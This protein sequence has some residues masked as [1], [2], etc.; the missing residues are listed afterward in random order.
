MVGVS[1]WA[2]IEST[3][4]T[5][6]GQV[7]SPQTDRLESRPILRRMQ[8]H[9]RPIIGSLDGA[10]VMMQRHAR[11]VLV[12][13]ALIVLPGVAV[14]LVAATLAFDRY[15][16][17]SGSIVSIP[18]LVGGSRASTGVE[19]LLWFIGVMVNSLSACLAG[20]YLASLVVRRHAGLALTIR[21]G[22]RGMAR[23][24]PSLLVAWLIGHSWFIL[25][26][27]GLR[28]VGGT[29]LISL[30]LL[31]LPVV[32]VLTTMTVVVAPAIVIERIGPFAGLA[33][34]WRLARIGF[35][36]LFGFTL[37]SVILG[38][39]VQYG[40]AYLPRLLEQTGLITFGRFGWLIEGVAGQLGRLVGLP[41][42]ALATALMYLEMRM[43]L[44]G[45]D[46][47]I[48]AER[49]FVSSP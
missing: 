31:G 21:T 12:G 3:P 4:V 40:I 45:M 2:G 7:A 23:C 37:A 36:T 27:W 24:I 33:R 5:D 41:I 39:V 47:S 15:E 43:A 35:G 19:E 34:A 25:S 42:I 10:G 6:A 18:E 20:G 48:E 16:S 1:A 22:Y 8:R 29:G 32:L 17:F 9:Q 28:G 11:E 30:I 44:E 13:S 26:A 14:N 46:L 38:S 49:V